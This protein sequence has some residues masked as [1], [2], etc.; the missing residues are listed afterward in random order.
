VVVGVV[1]ITAVVVEPVAI[2]LL[3]EHQEVV[4]PLKPL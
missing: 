1:Q 2:A 3:L 4:H